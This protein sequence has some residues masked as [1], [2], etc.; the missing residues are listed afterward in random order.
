MEANTSLAKVPQVLAFFKDKTLEDELLFGKVRQMVFK[1]LSPAEIDLVRDLIERNRL[2]KKELVWIFYHDNRRL[3]S[4]YLRPLGLHF[5][6][7]NTTKSN[8]L[9]EALSFV[10]Q[11]YHDKKHLSKIPSTDFPCSFL[12]KSWKKYIIDE[13]GDVV[14]S[15]YEMALYQ[16]LRNKLIKRFF[17]QEELEC[18]RFFT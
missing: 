1:T 7:E 3:I 18:Y 12:S 16:T 8:E 5:N 11:T 15:K 10:K 2:N 17:C 14:S 13:K 4:L 9:M 6:F